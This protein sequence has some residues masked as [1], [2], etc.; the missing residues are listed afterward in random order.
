M[1]CPL[2]EQSCRPT[3]HRRTSAQYTPL[4]MAGRS[5]YAL[6]YQSGILLLHLY[7]LSLC[8]SGCNSQIL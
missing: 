1:K 8:S 4:A 3:S 2:Y 6:K 5:A 7:S